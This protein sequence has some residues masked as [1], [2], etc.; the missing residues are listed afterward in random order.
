MAKPYELLVTD[1]VAAIRSGSLS[2]VE[3]VES[4]LDR[5]QET[6]PRLRAWVQIDA[7]GAKAQARRIQEIRDFAGRLPGIPMGFKDLYDVKG[8]STGAGFK[9]WEQKLAAS[10]ADAVANLRSHGTVALGKTV[11]TQFAFSDPSAT[12]NPW[13]LERTASGSSAGSGASVAARQVTAALGTQT[14]GS[15]LRPAA[16]NGIVGFKPS[17]G[18]LKRGGITPLA[19]SMDHPGILAR[20]VEDAALILDAMHEARAAGKNGA[21][22]GRFQ[23]AARAPKPLRYGVLVDWVAVAGPEIRA[24]VEHAAK[25]LASAG[26]Q[27]RELRIGVELETIKATQWTLLQVEALELHRSLFAA[28]KEHYAPRMRAMMEVAHTLPA[29]AYPKAE[30]L[31]RRIR[32]AVDALFEEVDCLLSPVSPDLPPLM[33]EGTTGDFSFLAAWS[34]LGLPAFSVPAGLTA[35]GLPLAIQLAA[36]HS[37]DERAVQAAA[38]SEG[39]LGRLPAPPL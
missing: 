31:R 24:G 16:Y 7:A 28:E 3:L 4:L 2:P 10:D 17:Y 6:E 26:A 19:W 13:D 29:W 12:R 34:L 5:I 15:T 9:P 22:P 20:S 35:G 1:A 14:T 27:V 8:L 38:W 21:E 39:V 25:T 23:K 37:H 32:A 30:R 36:R 18:L 11:T 33:S